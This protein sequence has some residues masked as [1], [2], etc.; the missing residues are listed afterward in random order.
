MQKIIKSTIHPTLP[1]M[2]C[3]I[4]WNVINNLTAG[5]YTE[6]NFGRGGGKERYK[7]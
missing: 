2:E 3:L 4:L 6:Y 5:T 7:I 1:G